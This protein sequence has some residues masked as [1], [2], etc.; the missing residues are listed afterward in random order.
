MSAL[1]PGIL[2]KDTDVVQWT[3]RVISRLALDFSDKNILNKAW[4]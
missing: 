4:N 2:S 1:K 3:F